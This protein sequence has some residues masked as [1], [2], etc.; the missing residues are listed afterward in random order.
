MGCLALLALPALLVAE[1]YTIVWVA[2]EIDWAWT[3]ILLF[4]SMSVGGS[5]VRSA[6]SR[7]MLRARD[8]LNRGEVP[9]QPLFDGVCLLAAGAL[10][11]FPG[12]LT[13]IAAIVLLLPPA[14]W[15][16]FKLFVAGVQRRASQRGDRSG[17]GQSG[18]A[19]GGR[20]HVFV[21]SSGGSARPPRRPT[22]SPASPDGV[23]DAEWT[24]VEDG[25][26]GGVLRNLPP[27]NNPNPKDPQTPT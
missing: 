13:D 19:F 24:D 18:G 11:V 23:I 6:G 3:L 21:W 22:R 2:V 14:R 9:A 1:I 5:L 4:I 10:F 25:T 26:N 17:A 20:P 12:F 16:L 7:T 8:V 27:A 15:V